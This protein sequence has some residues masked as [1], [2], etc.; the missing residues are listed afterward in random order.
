MSRMDTNL[1]A[2]TPEKD[3][4]QSDLHYKL[5]M[6]PSHTVLCNFNFKLASP[7]PPPPTLHT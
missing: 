2:S 5:C 3:P 7:P 6:D 1:T 4:Q